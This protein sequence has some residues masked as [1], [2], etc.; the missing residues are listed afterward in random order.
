[1]AVRVPLNANANANQ[2]INE[3]L[4]PIFTSDPGDTVKTTIENGEIYIGDRVV[5]AKA[6]G[7]DHAEARVLNNMFRH[8]ANDHDMLLFYVYASPCIERCTSITHNDRI[9]QSIQQI[10]QWERYALVFCKSF[11]PSSG[12][13]YTDQERSGVIQRLGLSIG[14]DNISRCDG[15]PHR[16]VCTSCATGSQVTPYCAEG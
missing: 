15:P 12:V 9:L 10:Q 5:A 13:T 4:R 6:Q 1:M 3:I 16:V 14:L 8:N 11:R 7:T 2:N